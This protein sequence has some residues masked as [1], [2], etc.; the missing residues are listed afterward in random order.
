MRRAFFTGG[1]IARFGVERITG[2][3]LGL[4]AV[5]AVVGL[6]GTSV[7]HFWASLILLGL[8]WTCPSSAPPPW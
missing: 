5:T 7:G 1:L 4:I 6:L 8:G 2:V 3:G